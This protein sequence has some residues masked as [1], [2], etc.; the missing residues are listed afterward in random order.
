MSGTGTT[1]PMV[2]DAQSL[3]S[4]VPVLL[5]ALDRLPDGFALYDRNFRPILANAKTMERFATAFETLEAGGTFLDANIAGVRRL[6]P[7]Y[8]E[9][10]VREVALAICETLQTGKPIA[11]KTENG[12][13]VQTTYGK[14][15]E[16]RYVATSVDITDLRDR[17]R[18]LVEARRAAESANDA[19]SA[20]LANISHEIRTPL[21]GILGMARMLCQSDLP[22]REKSQA[23]AILDSG[24]MLLDLLNDVLDLSKIDAGRMDIAP[25]EGDLAEIM[26]QVRK[27]WQPAAEEKGLKLSMLVDAD[28]PERLV[29]DAVRVRQC[30]G[31][32]VSNAVKFTE[33]GRIQIAVEPVPG[34]DG[35]PMV[36]IEV[37][38]D[39]IGIDET[40]LQRLFQPFSQADS[41]TARRYGGTGLGLSITRSLARMM[42]GDATATSKPGCGSVFALTFRVDLPE[43]ATPTCRSGSSAEAPASRPRG[44]IDGMRVLLVDDHA[45]NRKVASLYLEPH[46]CMVVEAGNGREALQRL[47]DQDFDVVLLD[48]HMPTMDGPE[49]IARIRASD[50]PWRDVPVI[51]LTADALSGDRERYLAMGM[52][53]YVSKPIVEREL[54]G[55]MARVSGRAAGQAHTTLSPSGESSRTGAGSDRS[56]RAPVH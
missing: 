50:A 43:G 18:E 41:S 47:G 54:V 33:R 5:E 22:E 12:R 27:L 16:G 4:M 29:F 20:F 44:S 56:L 31:N 32:L 40:T 13:I 26:R 39:G 21:N 53:G 55:E 10:K 42:G 30:V 52:N 7:H 51:A 36:R 11:L 35:A 24:Q 19:K 17:E 45:I 1:L 14:M 46:R 25:A 2:N 28:L 38:D 49:T 37:R 9:E 34:P 8:S 48:V 6:C 23:Q 15:S 3:A